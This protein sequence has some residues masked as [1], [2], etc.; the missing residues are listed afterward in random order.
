MQI[1]GFQPFSLI[2][3]PEKSAAIV[4][5]QGC[6]FR[7]A[8]CH[9]PELIPHEPTTTID[10]D[11]VLQTLQSRMKMLDGLVITGGEPTLQPDLIDFI[12]RV[13]A[14]G[15]L[16]KLDTNGVHPNIV[17]KLIS[18][19]LVDYFAMD[20][21][22]TWAKY[23]LVARTG[24]PRVIENCK[25]TFALIQESGIDHEFRTTV[26]PSLHRAEDFYEMVGYLK[27]GE[28]YFIQETRFTKTLD[29]NL[30]REMQF[31][32]HDL[33]PQLKQIAPTAIIE[34]R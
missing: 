23:D 6:V 17:A 31:S 24:N 10:P 3:F 19:H 22:H 20:L 25:Q 8:F 28:K 26:F 4:F 14:T 33:V 16:V 30:S 2:D 1:A 5:T 9:N 21:K 18:E 7:C 11:V 34:V 32:V 27:P 15:L 12:R 29:P 13:K